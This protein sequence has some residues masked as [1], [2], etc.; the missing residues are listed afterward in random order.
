VFH[1][2]AHDYDPLY[3]KSIRVCEFAVFDCEWHRDEL[4]K[5]QAPLYRQACIYVCNP[6]CYGTCIKPILAA[7]GVS[8]KDLERLQ[9][10]FKR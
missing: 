4:K 7:Y 3:F 2:F 6:G 8:L 9:D 5:N 10:E 1:Y